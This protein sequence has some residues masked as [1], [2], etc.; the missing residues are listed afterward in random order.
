MD[1]LSFVHPAQSASENALTIV[2][3]V[4]RMR[5]TKSVVCL[6]KRRIREYTFIYSYGR[7]ENGPVAKVIGGHKAWLVMDEFSDARS[8]SD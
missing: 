7:M 1:F 2:D 6:R 8:T 4:D 3:E 5:N